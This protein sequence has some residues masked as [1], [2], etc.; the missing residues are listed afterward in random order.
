MCEGHTIFVDTSDGWEKILVYVL[1]TVSSDINTKQVCGGREGKG[2]G[3][4]EAK[5]H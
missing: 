4:F 2:R 3:V 1:Y 5:I